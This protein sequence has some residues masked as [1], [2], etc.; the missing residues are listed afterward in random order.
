MKKVLLLLVMCIVIMGLA[1]VVATVVHDR[2]IDNTPMMQGD[3]IVYPAP[4]T[5]VDEDDR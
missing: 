1:F 2:H 4:D 3:D 5:V